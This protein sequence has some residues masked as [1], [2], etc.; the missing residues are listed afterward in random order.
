MEIDLIGI[1]WITAT[2]LIIVLLFVFLIY[3]PDKVI[4]LLNLDKGFDDDRIDFQ[5]L[6]QEGILN[7]AV[8]IVGGLVLLENNVVIIE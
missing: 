6:S 7:L 2:V 1:I 8:I 4:G 5:S 3:M